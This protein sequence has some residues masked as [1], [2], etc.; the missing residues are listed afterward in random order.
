MMRVNSVLERALEDNW[1]DLGKRY[2]DV[3]EAKALA[4]KR[5]ELDPRIEFRVF[6]ASGQWGVKCRVVQKR[7]MGGW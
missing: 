6:R 5:M 2:S 4:R 7:Y 1:F 3:D